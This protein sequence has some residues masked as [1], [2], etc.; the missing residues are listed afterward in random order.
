MS[1]KHQRK[2]LKKQNP[3]HNKSDVVQTIK[4]CHN[5]IYFDYLLDVLP[6]KKPL[7][8]KNNSSSGII[9]LVPIKITLLQLQLLL[10]SS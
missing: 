9:D 1:T 4:L 5:L 2:L 10:V 7:Q 6:I 3:E 8:L